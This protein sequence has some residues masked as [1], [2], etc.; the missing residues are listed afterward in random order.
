MYLKVFNGT[1]I[2]TFS[3]ENG[4]NE[5][6]GYDYEIMTVIICSFIVLKTHWGAMT[7]NIILPDFLF[8]ISVFWLNG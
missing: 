6:G 7:I 5:T 4:A 2:W 8:C 3:G 1:K